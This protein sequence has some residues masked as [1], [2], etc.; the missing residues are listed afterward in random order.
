MFSEHF[1]HCIGRI[2]STVCVMDGLQYFGGDFIVLIEWEQQCPL[3]M[4]DLTIPQSLLGSRSNEVDLVL[5]SSHQEILEESDGLESL[6]SEKARLNN[7]LSFP[8]QNIQRDFRHFLME[9]LITE[10]K[11]LFAVVV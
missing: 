6:V 5:I 4:Y 8:H 7:L 1:I 9:G 2:H 11:I 10:C 3:I